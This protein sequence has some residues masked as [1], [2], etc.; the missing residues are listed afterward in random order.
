MTLHMKYDSVSWEQ[1]THLWR[2]GVPNVQVSPYVMA[3]CALAPDE[4]Q[5]STDN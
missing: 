2:Q 1:K 3:F 5:I 4:N